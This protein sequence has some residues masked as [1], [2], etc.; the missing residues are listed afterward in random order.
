[1]LAQDPNKLWYQKKYESELLLVLDE[2]VAGVDTRI[3]RSLARIEATVPDL[4]K[5][6]ANQDKVNSINAL[7]DR[8]L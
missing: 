4:E 5:K 1:M 7:I 6:Q 2:L 8:K 3:R